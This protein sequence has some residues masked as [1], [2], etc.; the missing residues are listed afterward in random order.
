MIRVGVSLLLVWIVIASALNVPTDFFQVTEAETM[1]HTGQLPST[2]RENETKTFV[3][4]REGDFV[5]RIES[6][7]SNYRV[8]EEIQLRAMLKYVGTAPRAIIYHAASPFYFSLTNKSSQLT[9][10]NVMNQ[11]LITTKLPKNEWFIEDYIPSGGFVRI[12]K[13]LAPYEW[14]PVEIEQLPQG[15]YVLRVRADFYI[16]VPERSSE[17]MFS[18]FEEVEGETKHEFD[19]HTELEF[20]I[21]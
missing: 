20:T 11:P 8:G 21:K 14:E 15:D 4:V 5:L 13:N 12:D 9:S 2:S 10:I 19:F 6:E 17:G 18:L 1:N 3:E 16:F 7:S